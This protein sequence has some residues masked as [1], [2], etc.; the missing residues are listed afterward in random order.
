M[1]VILVK[2][3]DWIISKE[4]YTDIEPGIINVDQ[5]IFELLEKF[6]LSYS[7]DSEGFGSSDFFSISV[8]K[9]YGKVISPKNYV[10]V[11]QLSSKHQIEVLPKVDTCSNIRDLFIKMLRC[12]KDFPSRSIGGAA[13]R[14]DRL[15]LYEIF[16][17]MYISEARDLVKQGIKSDYISIEDNLKYYKGK[18]LFNDQI[19]H[20][21]IRKDR[22]YVMYD[23]FLIDRPENRLIKST[24][25]KL[26]GLS[27]SNEN[28]KEIRQLLSHFEMVHASKNYNSDFSKVK[29]DRNLLEY[30]ELMKWSKVFLLNKSFSTFTGDNDVRALLFPMEKLFEAY[31]GKEIKKQGQRLDCKVNLQDRGYYLF[32]HQFALRP[33]IVVEKADGQII[34]MDTKWKN[35]FD[36]PNINYGISQS[37]MYQ[38]Y[39]YAKKYSSN[40]IWLIYPQNNEM[41]G[42]K[43]IIYSSDD[44]V[45]VNI[46][47]VDLKNIEQSIALLFSRVIDGVDL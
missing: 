19:K 4:N 41:N 32:E 45:N 16:I 44:N 22:F 47:F 40:E 31:V 39:A 38:M 35:L 29:I 12:M 37:D 27:N 24:L 5:K 36:N 3:F 15:N 1:E 33:D 30:K 26:S 10:G 14:V 11:I 42:E 8:K 34:I 13:L 17:S 28:Q 7:I 6:V 18:L 23:E 43:V 20:N 46:F 2:E 21:T 9:K 25:L